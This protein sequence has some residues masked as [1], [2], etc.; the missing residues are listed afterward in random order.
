MECTYSNE[1]NA[2]SQN[3]TVTESPLEHLLN[4]LLQLGRSESEAMEFIQALTNAVESGR[5]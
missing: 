3:E 5:F 1:V 2:E 4:M